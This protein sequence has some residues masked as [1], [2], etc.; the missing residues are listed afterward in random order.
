MAIVRTQP[1]EDR[2]WSTEMK[3]ARCV[4]QHETTELVENIA[5]WLAHLQDLFCALV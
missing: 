1:L 4:Y 3:Y 5:L 2:M